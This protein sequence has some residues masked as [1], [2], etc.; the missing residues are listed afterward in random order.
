M[1]GPIMGECICP[2]RAGRSDQGQ[3]GNREAAFS[4]LLNT[5]AKS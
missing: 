2:G 3:A 4:G 5:S 1:Q